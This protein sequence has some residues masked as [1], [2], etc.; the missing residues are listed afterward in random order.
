MNVW[1][2]PDNDQKNQDLVSDPANKNILKVND[3]N[4]GND[5]KIAAHF[6]NY[7]NNAAARAM[8]VEG[9]TE[10]HNHVYLTGSLFMDGAENGI[11]TEGGDPLLLGAAGGCGEVIIGND[12][13]GIIAHGDIYHQGSK[14][15]IGH[16]GAGQI[17]ANT[18]DGAQ[19]LQLGTQ[20]TTANVVLSHA[21]HTIDMFGQ[22]R[23]NFGAVV[24]NSAV[25][26]GIGNGGTGLVINQVGHGNGASIDIYI[27]GVFVRYVDSAAWA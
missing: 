8:K 15:T 18:A 4:N 6:I 26:L 24:L 7:S 5:A 14:I 2:N 16:G 10:M 27:N 23:M 22:L 17:D 21:G 13:H 20:N 1:G 3:V 25:D 12:D 11:Y 19:D 9:L